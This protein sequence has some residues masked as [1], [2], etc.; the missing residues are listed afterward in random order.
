MTK[1]E[2]IAQN[3]NSFAEFVYQN[4]TE[5]GLLKALQQNSAIMPKTLEMERI[6][7]AA[8]FYIANYKDDSLAKLDK[9]NK[10][11]L[12]YGMQKE[13]MVYLEAGTDY[14]I[15][16]F[17]GKPV[18]CRKKDGWFKLIDM[19][20][21][22]EVARFVSNVATTG[23]TIRFNPVTEEVTH[24]MS[25]ERHQTSKDII[26]AYAYIKFANGF[27]KTVF[28]GK[29]DIQHARNLSPS[30]NSEYSPWNAHTIKMVETKVVKE[31]A[32]KLF[33]LF[34]RKL[35]PVMYGAA[36]VDDAPVQRITAAGAVVTEP[37]GVPDYPPE[38]PVY[39]GQTVYV[40]PET[41]EVDME[42][43]T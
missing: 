12:V 37:D 17:K 33:T 14:D 8:G 41:G 20:K 9:Q 3:E 4:K 18:I 30:K 23:D 27:E 28:W 10:L 39:N 32:K 42:S 13:A 22:A 7:A 2:L 26:A 25:G 34:G 31:L 24:E 40:D 1:N 29:E 16:V 35:S 21:P 38:P 36:L 15:V 6:A 5:V 43:L 11:A 19:I